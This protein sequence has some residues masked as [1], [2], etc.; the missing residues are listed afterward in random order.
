MSAAGPARPIL[1]DASALAPIFIANATSAP[2]RRFLRE[3]P[4]SLI[5]S[6]FAAGEFASVV[7]RYV[8]MKEF[9]EE[10]GRLVLATFDAWRPANTIGAVTE[11]ADL[12]VADSFVRRFDLKLRLPDAIYLATAQR[13]EAP[14]LTFDAV[15][16]E[17]A[18]A[19]GLPSIAL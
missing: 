12:R 15:Q 9:D 10:Q 6:D 17:A 1:L 2:I 13:L 16:A 3:E 4:R 18:L 5:V 7:A 8:R 11:P 19:L 14:L